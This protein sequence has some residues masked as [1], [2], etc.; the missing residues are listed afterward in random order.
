MAGE[1][2]WPLMLGVV[3]SMAHFGVWAHLVTDQEVGSLIVGELLAQRAE[4]VGVA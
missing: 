2:R 4:L 3:R 1:V